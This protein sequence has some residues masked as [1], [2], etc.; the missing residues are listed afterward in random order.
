MELKVIIF[1]YLSLAGNILMLP[2]H[3]IS[4]LAQEI[5]LYRYGLNLQ[6]LTNSILSRLMTLAMGR[7]KHQCISIMLMVTYGIW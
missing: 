2:I 4:I 7:D 1:L 3:Q 6:L 5:L